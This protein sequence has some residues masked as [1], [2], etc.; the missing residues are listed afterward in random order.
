MKKLNLS[1]S[2]VRKDALRAVKKQTMSRSR[3]MSIIRPILT[4]ALK[5]R[6]LWEQ[7][8]KNFGKNAL[9]EAMRAAL[10]VTFK[11]FKI[12]GKENKAKQETLNRIAQKIIELRKV[13]DEDL[14]KELT[15]IHFSSINVFHDGLMGAL[16]VE[17]LTLAFSDANKE[18]ASR[19]QAHE[20]YLIAKKE[21]LKRGIKHEYE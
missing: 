6:T 1:R 5:E 11:K 10:R 3:K 4:N 8:A 18:L 7:N 21:R 17:E 12:V 13:K 19:Q 14:Q 20:A 16:F 15:E 2:F 9:K